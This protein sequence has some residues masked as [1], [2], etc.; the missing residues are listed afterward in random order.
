MQQIHGYWCARMTL[1]E[2][3]IT[4]VLQT[5]RDFDSV[6]LVIISYY[7][8]LYVV[9]EILSEK[10][11]PEGLTH[12]ASE[13]LD[14]I[15][16]FKTSVVDITGSNGADNT[17]DINND[18][19]RKLIND[20]E[21]AKIYCLNFTMNLYNQ[22]LEQVSHGPWDPDLKRGLWCCIDL[23]ESILHLWDFDTVAEESIRKRIKFCKLYLSKLAKGQLGNDKEIKGNQLKDEEIT[24]GQEFQPNEDDINNVINDSLAETKEEEEQINKELKGSNN[25]QSLTT[26]NSTGEEDGRDG[27][28]LDHKGSEP[29]F[30]EVKDDTPK[31][32]D[33]QALINRL[34]EEG[35]DEEEDDD[36][37]G[38]IDL[39]KEEEDEEEEEVY[40][41]AEEL[42]FELPTAPTN[43]STQQTPEFID[44]D[45]GD[46]KEHKQDEPT[47]PSHHQY[48]QQELLE[49]MDQSAKIEKIQKLAKYAISA[50][51][52]EDTV[53]AKDQL[54]E[55]LNLLNTM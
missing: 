35:E 21:K 33:I 2:V 30:I 12:I 42:N 8:R 39:H 52:Y 9:E 1:T 54:T 38:K 4:R 16:Q 18:A 46:L 15:E 11:R 47:S 27:N 31:D 3:T 32:E 22:K 36:D 28:E 40:D 20:Q 43:I 51:N 29:D 6:G 23:F 26:S 5:A 50:L 10:D 7:L 13:L 55:A 19:L 41:E 48:S 34:K 37:E 49:M 24:N 14:A 44:S 53:T 45:N 17:E 25:L